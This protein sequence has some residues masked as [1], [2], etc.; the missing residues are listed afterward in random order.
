M[1]IIED[2]RDAADSLR[3][4]LSMQGFEVAAAYTGPDG[5]A[6]AHRFRPD[7]VVCDLGLPGMSGFDVARALR[8]DPGTASALLVCVSGYGQEQDKRHA[9]GRLR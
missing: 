9:R 8:A 4:L 2:C 5:L 6:A 7:A 3:L 1:L